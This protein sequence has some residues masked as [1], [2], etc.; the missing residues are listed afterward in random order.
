MIRPCGFFQASSLIRPPQCSIAAH[1]YSCDQAD[2]WG[3]LRGADLLGTPC[4]PT[5][6]RAARQR[7]TISPFNEPNTSYWRAGNN[8]EG[9]HFD[10][11]QQGAVVARLARALADSGL[12]AAGVGI[13]ASDETS[14]DTACVTWG[15]FS[16]EARAA[17]AQINTHSARRPRAWLHSGPNRV[18]SD[19]PA[20]QQLLA[21]ITHSARRPYAECRIQKFDWWSQLAAPSC[22]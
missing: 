2:Q 22:L 14:I 21:R 8:Q 17:L 1:A 9:C 7:R 18:Y 12:A 20:W 15:E 10:T 3:L 13:A 11:A 6:V 5:L 4:R 16:Q 19:R